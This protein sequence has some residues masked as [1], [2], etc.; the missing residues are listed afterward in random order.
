MA[1]TKFKALTHFIIKECEDDPSRL[2]ATRLN[3]AL[4]HTDVLSYRSTGASVTNDSYV[5]RQKGP[6]PS[7]ILVTIR[8]L[9]KSQSIHVSH[10]QFQFD[11]RRYTSLS[12]PDTTSLSEYDME[13]ARHVVRYLCGKTTTAISDETHD[14]V[15]KAAKDG[16]PIPLQ[17]TLVGR[18]GAITEEVSDWA[19]EALN[20]GAA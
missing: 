7:E 8:E 18:N 12:D 4:W 15:W 5:K 20:R 1:T 11:P 17:A 2:G 9:E 10:P 6:V 19:L 14:S 3:K 16:E 13:L